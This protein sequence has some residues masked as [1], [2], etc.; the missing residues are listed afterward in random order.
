M[1]SQDNGNAA[2]LEMLTVLPEIIEDQN[3]D[4]R[5]TSARRKEYGQEVLQSDSCNYVLCWIVSSFR[6]CVALFARDRMCF[7]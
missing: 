3:S 7:W 1:Q 2:V 5:V 6:H 4:F